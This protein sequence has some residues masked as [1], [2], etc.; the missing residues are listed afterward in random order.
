MGLA[1]GGLDDR[2]VIVHQISRSQDVTRAHH[3][4]SGALAPVNV[5]VPDGESSQRGNLCQSIGKRLPSTRCVSLGGEPLRQIRVVLNHFGAPFTSR[6]CFVTAR[7]M[8]QAVGRQNH[9]FWIST[10][11]PWH[12][13]IVSSMRHFAP[14]TTTL[15][16]RRV[17]WRAVVI[18][19]SPS[20]GSAENENSPLV[21]R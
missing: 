11:N 20:V 13:K 9:T 3:S 1:G 12:G 8:W 19:R 14:G 17:G 18:Q 16:S 6:L 5:E 21:V 7:L 4:L 10:P 2:V 15:T